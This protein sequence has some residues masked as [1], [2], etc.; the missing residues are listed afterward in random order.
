MQS[1]I[2]AL[3]KAAMRWAMSEGSLAGKSGPL[4]RLL[5]YER[6]D[7]HGAVQLAVLRD[8]LRCA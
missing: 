8:G 6:L 4:D 1:R 2:V 7:A 5:G 3:L